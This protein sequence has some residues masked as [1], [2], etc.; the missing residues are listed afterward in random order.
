MRAWEGER[1]GGKDKRAASQIA[2]VQPA[3]VS[4]QRGAGVLE[5]LTFLV[6]S[7]YLR[8]VTKEMHQIAT[9]DVVS[10]EHLS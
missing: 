3:T 4:K 2:R 10:A 7:L 9:L 8:L 1:E 5:E 6:L